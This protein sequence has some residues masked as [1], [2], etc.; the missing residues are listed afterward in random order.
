MIY[1]LEH[2]EELRM[3]RIIDYAIIGGIFHDRKLVDAIK[4]YIAQGWQPY[5]NPLM[6]DH[7]MVQVM[8]K[9]EFVRADENQTDSNR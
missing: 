2:D 9:Y 5:G 4:E 8:V 7:R 3:L 1:E 6:E